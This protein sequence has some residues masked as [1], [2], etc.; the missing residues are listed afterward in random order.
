M[1]NQKAET[2]KEPNHCWEGDV[3]FANSLT[4]GDVIYKTSGNITFHS[5]I[6][7]GYLLAESP[8]LNKM[9]R[10]LQQGFLCNGMQTLLEKIKG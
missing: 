8:I 10:V 3:A 2:E 1:K 7:N 9:D 4:I 6:E 5:G